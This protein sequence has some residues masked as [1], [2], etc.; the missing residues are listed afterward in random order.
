MNNLHIRLR[1]VASQILFVL[2]VS[3]GFAG[4]GIA[5][6]VA[7]FYILPRLDE[8]AN[9]AWPGSLL[10]I[11]GFVAISCALVFAGIIFTAGNISRDRAKGKRLMLDPERDIAK[12]VEDFGRGLSSILGSGIFITS[13]L[14]MTVGA[15]G[16]FIVSYSEFLRYW[17]LQYGGFV[18]HSDGYLYWLSYGVSWL[19]DNGLANFGQIYGL[20]ISDVQATNLTTQTLVWIYNV[21]LEVFAVA[22]VLR[23]VQ[24]LRAIIRIYFKALPVTDKQA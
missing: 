21:I 13:F 9:T 18:A 1:P 16:W 4:Y 24:G 15:F 12:E 5:Q 8:W 10:F 20:N 22:A 6:V 11:Y 2:V 3:L 23:G 17:Y 14:A 19:L 7:I